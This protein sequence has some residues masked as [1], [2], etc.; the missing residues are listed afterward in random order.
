MST[1]SAGPQ[2]LGFLHQ[3]R[4]ALVVLLEH[5]TSEVRLET[6]DDIDLSRPGSPIELLQLKHRAPDTKL[7]DASTDL[8]K[9][10]R[11]WS[12]LVRDRLIDADRALFTLVTTAIAPAESA[13][14]YLR[15]GLSRDTSAAL[16]KL[17]A[18]MTLSKNEELKSSFLVFGS[19]DSG[20]Q[21]QLLSRVYVLDEGPDIASARSF[22]ENRLALSVRREHRGAL[23]DRV[24]GWWFRRC[25]EHL[26]G[27]VPS[28]SGY[29]AYDV[30]AEL[31]Q[32]FERDALPI[33]FFGAEPDAA[34]KKVLAQ[35]VFV[36]Q[37]ECIGAATGRIERAL[38]DYYRAYAQRSRWARDRLLVGDEIERYEEK[39]HDEWERMRLVLE[40]ELEQPAVEEALQKLGRTL[41]T[42]M[43]TSADFRIRANVTEPY[44][45]RGSYHMLAD[46]APPRVWWHPDFVSRLGQILRPEQL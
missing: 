38:I 8:W 9:T 25:V 28:L 14:A 1:F 18:V 21:G 32:Q 42:W 17:Q 33:D 44:I 46:Q 29:E 12:T 19:L 35:R 27:K 11:V 2:T 37:L 24:E 40:N 16:G 31:A 3:V 13:A 39:L 23:T 45:M 20:L 43:E 4:Y 15:P 22:L 30:I 34:E 6:L 36:R 5:E 26:Q 7:T 41:L 10:L